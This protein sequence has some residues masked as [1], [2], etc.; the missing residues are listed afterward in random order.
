MK[1]DGNDRYYA[2]MSQDIPEE[3]GGDILGRKN[4][5]SE[6]AREMVNILNDEIINFNKT[7]LNNEGEFN[8]SQLLPNLYGEIIIII[9][10]SNKLIQINIPEFN[11]KIIK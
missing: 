8:F 7:Y 3:Y 6:K 2:I 11:K 5:I 9:D 4:K 1:N 10:Y